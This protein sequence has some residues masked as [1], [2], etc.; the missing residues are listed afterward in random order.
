MRPDERPLQ[1][2]AGLADWRL[3]GRLNRLL[4]E[5]LFEG[6]VREALLTVGAPRLPAQ[7]V[8]LYGLGDKAL[9]DAL[10]PALAMVGRAGG[11]EVACAPFGDTE[12]L[13]E[14][15]ERVAS[16]ARDAGIERLVCLADRVEAAHKALVVVE[17]HHPWAVLD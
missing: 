11:L 8:F 13:V 10:A 12:H 7:R 4:R 14:R 1:G 3:L 17:A 16:A 15:A 5:G 6:R 9:E 2:L